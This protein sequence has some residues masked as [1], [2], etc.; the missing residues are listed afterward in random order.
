MPAE[1]EFEKLYSDYYDIVFRYI[2]SLC[3]DEYFAEEITQDAFFKALKS[4]KSFRGDC[5]PEVWLCQIAKNTYFTALKKQ[6]R[7]V[8]LNERAHERGTPPNTPADIS[9]VENT[10]TLYG[11]LH[12]LPDPYKEVFWMRALGNLSFFEIGAVFGKSESW[13]RVTYHR[14]RLM[15]KEKML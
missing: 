7:T 2:L 4:I 1:N 12:T 15:L 9:A 11:V 5:K 10:L 3:K 6:K 13:A 14:A 8:P